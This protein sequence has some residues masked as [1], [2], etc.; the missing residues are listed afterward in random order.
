MK[1]E[2][3]NNSPP[4]PRFWGTVKNPMKTKMKLLEISFK[5][6]SVEA[7][8]F[9]G[10]LFFMFEKQCILVAPLLNVLKVLNVVTE[11]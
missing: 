10:T 8:L 3:L 11:C 7:S 4:L 1:T 5:C 2:I 9:E 6:F